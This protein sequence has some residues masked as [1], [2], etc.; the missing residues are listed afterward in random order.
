MTE[1]LKK[2]GGWFKHHFAEHAK[3]LERKTVFILVASTILLIVFHDNGSSSFFRA[4][5]SRY[6][7]P[8]GYARLY[9]AFYWYGCS[10]L[11]LG[12]VPLLLG[13]FVLK[14]PLI[15]WGVGLGDW[16]FGLKASLG[17]FVL[18]L[19]IL[20]YVSYQPSFQAKYPL[21][22]AAGSS[23]SHFV[24]YQLAYA[25]YFI[26]WEFI[27]RGFMLFGLK[28]KLGA[29][30]IFIQTIPFAIMHF[31][32]PEIE[33]LAAVFAGVILGFL[34]LRT[35]SFWYGWLLHALV[36]LSNDMLAMAHKLDYL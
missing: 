25:A 1:L 36:A 14:K 3:G 33:T 30:A 13:R 34:A 18:F 11:M 21:Y 16:R 31:G 15:E 28:P 17:L 2:G 8:G 26:G 4:H 35:R 5:F 20:L 19:P 32:K 29:Y 22:S 27:F 12:V 9:P 23:V 24:I 6:F 7:K 10:L